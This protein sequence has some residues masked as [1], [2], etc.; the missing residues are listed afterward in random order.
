[1]MRRS[2][3]ARYMFR[4][5]LN[6]K[7]NKRKLVLI[8][9]CN[10][11]ELYLFCSSSR[12]LCKLVFGPAIPLCNEFKCLASQR[13]CYFI[14]LLHSKAYSYLNNRQWWWRSGSG[15]GG[16]GGGGVCGAYGGATLKDGPD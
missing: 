7:T 6:I 11:A 4:Y 15:G 16:G 1:M 3:C 9:N 5:F 14:N 10:V 2:F 13:L 12:S 8:R